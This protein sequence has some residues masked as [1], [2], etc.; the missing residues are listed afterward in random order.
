MDDGVLN[1]LKFVRMSEDFQEYGR[2]ISDTML[3][4]KI[5][6]SEAYQTFL[7][8]STSLI[9]P[10]KTRGKDLKRKNALVTPK[11]KSLISAD[12]N[13]IPK[14]DVALELGNSISQTEA[15][16]AKEEILLHETHERLVTAK[17]TGVEESDES[18]GEPANRPTGRRRLSEERLAANTKKAIKASKEAFRL[19]QQTGDSSQG[20]GITPEVPDELTGKTSSE[21]VGTVPEVPNEEKGSSAAKSDAKI[22]W[23][24]EDDSHQS[25]EEFVNV[26]D[27]PW[28]FTEEEEKGDKMMMKNMMIGVEEEKG[29][30]EEKQADDDQAQEDQVDDDV[31]GTLVTMLQKEKLEVPR[32][33]SSQSLSSNYDA[34]VPLPEALTDVL[35]R[36]STLE[37]EVKELNQFDHSAVLQKHTTE[38]KKEL[39]QQE[40]Q[41]SASGIIK[42]KQ[43]HAS[44]QKWPKHLSKPFDKTA[45]NEYKQKD[46]LFQM[47]IAS[48]SYERHPAHKELYDALLQ[49]LFMD[50]DDMDKAVAA[51]QSTQ[52]KRKH[53]DQDE[54]PT[55][56]SD[57]GKG[58]KRPRKDTQ[59]SKKSSTSKESSKGTTS[60]KTSKSGK[61]VSAKEPDEEHVHEVIMDAE[62]NIANE[63]GNAKEQ[64]DKWNKC[65]VVDD[66]PEQTWFNNMIYAEKD[67]LTFDELMTL[68]I[69]FSKFAM[70]RLKIDKLTKTHLVGPVYE[71]LK[72]NR[73]LFD[74]RKPLPLKG[75]PC[76]L[77][78]AAE[79]FFN[80]DLEYLKS[81]NSE[82]KYT[83]S[84]T[85]MKAAR[86]EL[87]G[88]EDMIPK[89]SQLKRLLKHDVYSPLKILSVVRVKV[90]KLHG[91][92]YLEE[93]M[94]RRANRQLYTF[95]EGDF[96]NLHL[97]EINVMLLLVVQHN[98]FHLDG[99]VIVDLAVALR[100]FTRSLMS[101]TSSRMERS[102]WF[103]TL[104]ITSNGTSDWDTTKTSREESGQLRIRNDLIDKLMLER[105]IIRNLER[106]GNARSLKMDYKLMKRTM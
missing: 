84:I 70:N 22:D 42:T 31:V 37:K 35:Q 19:Q 14:P 36:V 6:K 20:A 40:S 41:K 62:G 32:S 96:V 34:S 21:G 67:P 98:L 105:R 59:Q 104:S 43:E 87:V 57:R 81:S 100:M 106:L 45:K 69:D 95:K 76:H 53:D 8:L 54:D 103:E 30:E 83:T 11:K 13:I 4:E 56:G 86:F 64:P 60:S 23:G 77:T 52:V 24:S 51:D 39:K 65:Q 102:S 18:D 3:T 58:K 15:E 28:V 61:S 66:Q 97:N 75:R 47:M 80:N 72:G 93:I 50:E 25:D 16:I 27:I 48:K 92:G 44:K 33:S 49:S 78:V 74:M 73:C 12:D 94:V 38:L 89:L 7:A 2:A 79:Y 90:K 17:P 29:D 88:I 99:D 55:A 71:L 5:K 10:K 101:S 68:P 1:K 91:Y 63:M 46:I 85:K 9:P 82:R 26:D